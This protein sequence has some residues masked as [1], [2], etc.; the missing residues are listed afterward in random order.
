MRITLNLAL[1]SVSLISIS[2]PA[3]PQQ[4]LGT[5]ISDH[6]AT[7]RRY[8]VNISYRIA[9]KLNTITVPEPGFAY[10]EKLTEQKLREL[11]GDNTIICKMIVEPPT[12]T[13]SSLVIDQSSGS[14]DHDA[15]AI[16]FIKGAGPY[17]QDNSLQNT[18]YIRFPVLQV[19]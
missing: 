17:C 15:K 10:D 6:R 4:E 12:G 19:R 7:F 2:P 18:F 11:F 3:M 1:V 16:D 8:P 9:K 13:I 14:K 5:A